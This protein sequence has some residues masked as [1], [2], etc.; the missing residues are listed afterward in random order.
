MKILCPRAGSHVQ[1]GCVSLKEATG[2]LRHNQK[3]YLSYPV[4][5]LHQLCRPGFFSP[6]CSLLL[7]EVDPNSKD[8]HFMCYDVPGLVPV[9]PGYIRECIVE[10]NPCG[11]TVKGAQG[12]LESSSQM[13]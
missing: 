6:E 4:E 10:A 2:P 5:D 9:I 12:E 11:Y 13:V 3:K 7:S 8:E 1:S